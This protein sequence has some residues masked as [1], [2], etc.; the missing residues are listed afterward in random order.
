MV[1]IKLKLHLRDDRIISEQSEQ[2]ERKSVST[3]FYIPLVC[4][5]YIELKYLHKYLTK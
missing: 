2:S 1:D 5:L 4:V 3:L